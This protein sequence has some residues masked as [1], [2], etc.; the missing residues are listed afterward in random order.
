MKSHRTESYLQG[1]LRQQRDKV[2]ISSRRRRGRTAAEKEGEKYQT[3]RKLGQPAKAK[4][5]VAMVEKPGLRLREE[6]L[7]RAWRGCQL[8]HSQVQERRPWSL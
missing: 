1:E 4:V 6:E 8:L 5:R 3:Q 7:E 2:K